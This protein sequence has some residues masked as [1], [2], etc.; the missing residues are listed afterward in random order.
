MIELQNYDIT[1]S[2]IH[3]GTLT[4]IVYDERRIDPVLFGVLYASFLDI[5]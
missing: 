2:A 5:R 1:V 3:A 4:E